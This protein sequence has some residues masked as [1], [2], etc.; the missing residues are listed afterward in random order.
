M[1]AQPTKRHKLDSAI[2]LG[3]SV[4][5]LIVAGALQVLIETGKRLERRVAQE[6]F[7]F[8]PIP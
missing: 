4:D 3:A 7:I 1:L 6:A 5:L 2:R 8:R